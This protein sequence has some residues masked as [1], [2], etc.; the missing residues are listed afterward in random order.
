MRGTHVQF[1]AKQS[2]LATFKAER[3]HRL[4]GP[5][6][7]RPQTDHLLPTPEPSGN[8]HDSGRTVVGA[9][10]FTISEAWWEGVSSLLIKSESRLSYNILYVKS[11]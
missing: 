8:L 9:A 5:R 7:C 1:P 2:E 4:L 11:C 10:R 3:R 6:V